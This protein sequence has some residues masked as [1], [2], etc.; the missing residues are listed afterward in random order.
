M[1][2][3]IRVSGLSFIFLG[4]LSTPLFGQV[5]LDHYVGTG[6]EF[7]T[8]QDAIDNLQPPHRIIVKDGTYNENIDYKGKNLSI[9]SENPGGATIDGGQNGSVV[10]FDSGENANAILNGFVITNGSATYGGGII[11][12]GS[13]P[14][15]KNNSI[16][17]NHGASTGGG[18]CCTNSANPVIETNTISENSSAYGGGIA[19]ILGSNPD[20]SENMIRDHDLP[21]DIG[22]GIYCSYFSATIESNTIIDNKANSGGGIACVAEAAPYIG[23]NLIGTFLQNQQYQDG[24][25]EAYYGGGIFCSYSTPEIKDGNYIFYNNVNP[26]LNPIEGGGIF[27]ESCSD[28]VVISQNH[29]YYN[30]CVYNGGGIMARDSEVTILSNFIR[31]NK[32]NAQDPYGQQDNL[33]GGSGIHL[34]EPSEC[35]IKWNRIL[36]NEDTLK[37]CGGG[38][39]FYADDG[40]V[41][42]IEIAANVIQNNQVYNGGAGIYYDSDDSEADI[43]NNLIVRNKILNRSQY[44]PLGGAGLFIMNGDPFIRNC[45]L[46]LNDVQ[47]PLGSGSGSFCA[48][49]VAAFFQNTIIY[50][51]VST[52][53]V[54]NGGNVQVEYCDIGGGVWPGP[55]NRSEDPLF[56][57]QTW[58][59]LTF[60]DQNNMSPCIDVGKREYCPPKDFE[61]EDRPHPNPG[62]PDIGWDEN[63]YPI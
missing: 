7:T 38:I 40:D 58:F 22:G 52:E 18:I 28:E 6:E 39:Y 63:H 57:D 5:Q 27:L 47:N 36:D 62:F 12:D 43:Y 13:S 61:N 16:L 31:Y 60:I 50:N 41:S 15:I 2:R 3:Y 26:S 10:T 51:N 46:S 24:G 49:P 44:T 48:A 33:Y 29:I 9:R 4:I 56:V 25:N 35:L 11:C 20:I 37:G 59:R 32:T 54:V 14:T 34:D 30:E 23:G 17:Q 19:C 45:T 21:I 8:I 42:L 55:G 53:L 1:I